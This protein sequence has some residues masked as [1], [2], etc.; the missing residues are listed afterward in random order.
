[1]KNN[2]NKRSKKANENESEFN[3]AADRNKAWESMLQ[4]TLIT[5]I[6]S[7]KFVLHLN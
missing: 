1:M 3:F 4:A 7:F 6:K 5:Q 2:K